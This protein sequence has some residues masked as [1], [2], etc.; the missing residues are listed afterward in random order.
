M[1]FSLILFSSFRRSSKPGS[2]GLKASSSI[3][4]PTLSPPLN[5]T[6]ALLNTPPLVHLHQPFTLEIVIRNQHP[7]RTVFPKV[8]LELGA[9][10]SF[11]VAGVRNGRLPALIPGGEARIIWQL[12]PLECGPAV[13]LPTI[14]LTDSR[15]TQEIA[16]SQAM[17]VPLEA[18]ADLIRII[19]LHSDR[20]LEDGS[21][22]QSVVQTTSTHDSKVSGADSALGDRFRIAVSSA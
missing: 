2:Y 8:S 6:V 12:I 17:D 15:R 11:V 4:L 20:R 18:S 5:G 7:T 19:P 22:I 3:R 9:S 16:D 21:D 10:E 14:K 13:P 1:F